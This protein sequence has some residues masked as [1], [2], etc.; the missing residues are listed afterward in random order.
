MRL[1]GHVESNLSDRPY[2]H[3]FGAIHFCRYENRERLSRSRLLLG[4]HHHSLSRHMVGQLCSVEAET[5][6][7]QFMVSRVNSDDNSPILQDGSKVNA[8]YGRA[9]A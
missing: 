9:F 1:A 8:G 2:K 5:F 4:P 3:R 6:E 7:L